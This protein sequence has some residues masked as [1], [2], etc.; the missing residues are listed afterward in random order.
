MHTA[1][2]AQEHATCRGFALKVPSLIHG[3]K[4]A[5]A[6]ASS[7]SDVVLLLL[8]IVQWE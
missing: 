5:S 4:T 8:T 3:N 6:L 1:K 2:R 7:H